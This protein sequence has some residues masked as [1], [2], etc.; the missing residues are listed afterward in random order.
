MPGAPPPPPLC[1]TDRYLATPLRLR[2]AFP[3]IEL[4]GRHAGCL[5]Y[6]EPAY[7]KPA[8]DGAGV[9]VP[10]CRKCCARTKAEPPEHCFARYPFG[11]PTNC[12]VLVDGALV[13]ALAPLTV[14]EH[15]VVAAL[16]RYNFLLVIKEQC[17][18]GEV[19]NVKGNCIGFAQKG[20]L[21]GLHSLFNSPQDFPEFVRVLFLSPDRKF[22]P[23]PLIALI[24]PPATTCSCCVLSRRWHVGEIIPS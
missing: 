15:M 2:P 9:L 21:E 22:H 1:A 12:T 6:V 13:P 17:D 23:C 8:T 4:T 14:V 16:R 24:C 11:D 18:R 19:P 10:M 20:L 5:A 7:V 3:V